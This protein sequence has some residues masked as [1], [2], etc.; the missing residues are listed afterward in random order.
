MISKISFNKAAVYVGRPREK[1]FFFFVE[2]F[3]WKGQRHSTSIEKKWTF[4]TPK[5]SKRLSVILK[6]GT[7]SIKF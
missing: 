3:F 7:K 6:I 5:N 1:A 4:L 2:G